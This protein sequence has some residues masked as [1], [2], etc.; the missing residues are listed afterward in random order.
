MSLPAEISKT[1]SYAEL[2]RSVREYGKAKFPGDG[3]SRIVFTNGCF[4]LLHLGHLQVLQH[5][6]NLA[7]PKGAVVVGLNSDQSVRSLKGEGRPI[8]DENTRG[9]LLVSLR[10]VDHVISF[11]EATPLELIES[12]RPDVIVKGGDYDPLNVV[13]RHLALVS[14]APFDGQHS[15]SSIIKRIKES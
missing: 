8:Q 12:L 2:S 9:L 5:A 10:M 1:S 13:G 3:Y 14:I 4:D 7:G 15:T 11:D 6:R